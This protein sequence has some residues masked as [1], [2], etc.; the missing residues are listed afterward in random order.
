VCDVAKGY[1][2]FL[3]YTKL[4]TDRKFRRLTHGEKWGCYRVPESPTQS[5]GL[6]L[7]EGE[8]S[9]S[10]PRIRTLKPEIW[11]DEAVGGLGPWERLLFV[12]LITMADD[13]G[14]LRALPSAIAGHIFPY[15]ELTP[16][17]ILKWLGS[18]ADAGLIHRYR[19]GA[20]DYVQILG[21]AKHQKINRPAPSSLPPPSVNG[22]RVGME[23]AG[24]ST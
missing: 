20:T 5:C 13:E 11:E 15:D 14:R 6:Q 2:L 10:R 17:K 4:G 24:T 19:A 18:I 16:P 8:P 1:D 7:A 12:G 9:M 3:V 23:K 22:H 21:W